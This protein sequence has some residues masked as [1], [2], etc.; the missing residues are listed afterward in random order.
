GMLQRI[1]IAQALINDPKLVLLD[2]PMSGLDPIGRK[3]MR[4]LILRLKSEG[5]TVIY[6]SHILSDVKAICDRIAILLKGRL[7][8]VGRIEELL[9]NGDIEESF[10]R[11][12]E[13]LGGETV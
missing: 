7:L 9:G 10:A 11:K 3:W 8:G 4:E 6:S 1:G 2:E 13:M 12:V 5:R